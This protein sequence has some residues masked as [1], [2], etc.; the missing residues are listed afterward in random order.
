FHWGE[1][2]IHL[3]SEVITLVGKLAPGPDYKLYLSPKFVETEQ[4]FNDLKSEMS[5][6]G[7][8][9]TFDNFVVEVPQST[10]ISEYNTVVVWCETFGEF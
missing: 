6:I 1:G 8:V 2:E 7:D 5:L 3:S 10:S 9:K 4:E